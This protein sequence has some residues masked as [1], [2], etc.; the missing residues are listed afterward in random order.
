MGSTKL[1]R[2]ASMFAAV[3]LTAT[4][5]GAT[6][7]FASH[8][9]S[10]VPDNQPHHENI[11]ALVAAGCATGFDD[12]TYRPGDP[13]TRGQTARQIVQC[14]TRI[15]HDSNAAHN[16][17]TDGTTVTVGE[18][19]MVAGGSNPNTGFVRVDG[20]ATF[21]GDETADCP[22]RITVEVRNVNTNTT[23]GTTTNVIGPDEDCVAG[24]TCG[25]ADTSFVFPA[26]NTTAGNSF[27]ANAR[28]STVGDNTG[29]VVDGNVI[30]TYVPFGPDPADS[31]P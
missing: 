31:T 16:N 5:A 19:S 29:Y 27:Q 14:G 3:L 24:L 30:V 12:G 17:P 28:L 11:H 13:V 4:I 15:N 23:A 2:V 10:D 26:G 18:A 7:A 1:R 21:T 8:Q 22:C 25:S 20:F 6:G 9:F